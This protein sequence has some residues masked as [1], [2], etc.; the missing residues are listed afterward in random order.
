MHEANI[1]AIE[2]RGITTGCDANNVALYCPLDS[3]TRAQMATLLVTAASIPPAPDLG[4]FVDDD[5]NLHEPNIAALATA[6]VTNGCDAGDPT[7]YCPD[8][9]V[10]RGQMASFLVRAFGLDDPMF[11]PA[12]LDPYSDDDGNIHEANIASIAGLGITN[13]CD[14]ADP[15]LF[16]PTEP[17]TRGQIGQFHRKDTA[18][19]WSVNSDGVQSRKV[20]SVIV[21]LS[22][23]DLRTLSA[24]LTAEL[25]TSIVSADRGHPAVS[26]TLNVGMIRQ[27][28][29]ETR[30]WWSAGPSVSRSVA[31]AGRETFLLVYVGLAFPE[32]GTDTTVIV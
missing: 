22:P 17:V 4:P 3:L 20:R 2:E 29:G 6:G 11:A 23:N 21:M 10:T 19:A 31:V 12:D 9:N 5:G 15:T 28:C 24:L 8:A 7:L 32:V 26:R 13:G 1:E 25:T 30:R 27:R 16:C 18:G 14:A